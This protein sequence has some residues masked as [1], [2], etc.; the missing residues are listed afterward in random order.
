[1]ERE[2]GEWVC[3]GHE[4][5]RLCRQTCATVDRRVGDVPGEQGEWTWGWV[6]KDARGSW[7][8]GV[9]S[10]PPGS[11]KGQRAEEQCQPRGRRG[12]GRQDG[13]P[14]GGADGREAGPVGERRGAFQGLLDHCGV[15]PRVT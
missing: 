10:C 4:M 6:E 15:K 12:G 8:R 7:S 1:M 5:R 13:L 14:P 9:S 11:W 3:R 2:T